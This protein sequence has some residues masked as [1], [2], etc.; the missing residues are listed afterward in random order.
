MNA[1][2]LLGLA[3]GDWPGHSATQVLARVVLLAG[4]LIAL[5]AA[6]STPPAP[7]HPPSTTTKG[8]RR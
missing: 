1:H 2:A 4:P 8:S 6:G 5:Y 7:H 3:T